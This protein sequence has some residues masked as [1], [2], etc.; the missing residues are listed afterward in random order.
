M[1]KERGKGIGGFDSGRSGFGSGEEGEGLEY[2][3]IFFLS[4]FLPKQLIRFQQ[5]P[6]GSNTH[7]HEM[8]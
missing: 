7:T 1:E 6:R 4:N 2:I 5:T 8:V 3:Y